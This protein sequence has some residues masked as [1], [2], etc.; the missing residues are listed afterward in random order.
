MLTV[1]SFVWHFTHQYSELMSVLFVD[2]LSPCPGSTFPIGGV[3][4][5]TWHKF[6]HSSL[7]C[8]FWW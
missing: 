7:G 8:L 4:W 2:Q 6:F 3:I 5:A 1:A